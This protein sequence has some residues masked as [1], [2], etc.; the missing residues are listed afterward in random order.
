MRTCNDNT[1]LTVLVVKW[2]CIVD[3]LALLMNNSL[4]SAG[5]TKQTGRMPPDLSLWY[6]YDV[7]PVTLYKNVDI[8]SV[9]W[10]MSHT[11]PTSLLT[12]QNNK[13]LFADTI[14]K[15]HTWRTYLKQRWRLHMQWNL[16][17][18]NWPK[19]KR[20][21]SESKQRW[22]TVFVEITTMQPS[23]QKLQLATWWLEMA[24][25]CVVSNAIKL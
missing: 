2:L 1:Y 23:S 19:R 20:K 21:L 3:N 17:R 18:Q 6:E 22:L 10:I 25:W 11:P 4:F 7:K 15:S 24:V 14:L 12:M 9:W 5:L 8:C 16:V 13:T